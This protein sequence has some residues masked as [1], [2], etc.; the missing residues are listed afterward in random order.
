MWKAY[1]TKQ[2]YIPTD[3]DSEINASI[4]TDPFDCL[5]DKIL[6]D[7]KNKYVAFQTYK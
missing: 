5:V 2:T 4:D 3:G 6:S 7:F 1:R